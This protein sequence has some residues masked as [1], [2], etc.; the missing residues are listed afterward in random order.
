MIKS[1]YYLDNFRTNKCLKKF[2]LPNLFLCLNVIFLEKFKRP[3][4]YLI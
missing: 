3:F 2:I 4:L 1:V